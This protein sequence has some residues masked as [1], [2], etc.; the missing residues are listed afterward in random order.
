MASHILHNIFHNIADGHFHHASPTPAPAIPCSAAAVSPIFA[1]SK[2]SE[3][4]EEWIDLCSKRSSAQFTDMLKTPG[5]PEILFRHLSQRDAVNVLTLDKLCYQAVLSA[6]TGKAV[7]N[8]VLGMV[9]VCSGIGNV[10]VDGEEE[11]IA[12]FECLFCKKQLCWAHHTLFRCI[13][14][15]YRASLCN[16][17]RVNIF[18]VTHRVSWRAVRPDRMV[19]RMYQCK[20][21]NPGDVYP[22]RN[23]AEFENNCIYEDVE[24][25]INHRIREEER[26]VGE[27][28]ELHRAM[29]W[30]PP[31]ERRKEHAVDDGVGKIVRVRGRFYV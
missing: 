26:L 21:L 5:L 22:P 8:R 15:K 16:A 25:V 1:S 10:C 13:P 12:P 14:T 31:A 20:C 3:A 7:G 17:C 2:Y 11:M 9:G 4:E 29:G 19:Q 28:Q 30:G 27:V 6:V 24:I 23:A 18:D